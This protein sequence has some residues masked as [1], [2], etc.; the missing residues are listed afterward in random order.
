M[1][2]FWGG[3]ALLPLVVNSTVTSFPVQAHLS[4]CQH[5]NPCM[6]ASTSGYTLLELFWR[7]A[8]KN[9]WIGFI[10]INVH[11][12]AKYRQTNPARPAVSTGCLKFWKCGIM[13]SWVPGVP[14]FQTGLG[15]GYVMLLGLSKPQ[16]EEAIP[17]VVLWNWLWVAK[18]P[19]LESS[20]L[21]MSCRSLVDQSYVKRPL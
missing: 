1:C 8:H 16:I 9:F 11:S 15:F 13:W 5:Q 14:L 21:Q 7:A 6:V 3:F 19:T 12:A 20:Q 4:T 17:V 10:A 18:L 2:F